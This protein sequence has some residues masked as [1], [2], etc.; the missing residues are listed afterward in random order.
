M[1]RKKKATINLAELRKTGVMLFDVDGTILG[2]KDENFANQE[3]IRTTFNKSLEN[4]RLGIISGNSSD[5]QTGRIAEPLKSEG[6][7]VANLFLYV[8]GGATRVS[9]NSRGD[10]TKENLADTISNDDIAKVQSIISRLLKDNLGLDKY[11]VEGWKAWLKQQTQEGADFEGVKFVPGF[12]VDSFE[13]SV[14]TPQELIDAKADAGKSDPVEITNP[15]IE[16]RDGVQLSIKL[17]PRETKIARKNVDRRRMLQLLGALDL[18]RQ[19]RLGEEIAANSDLRVNTDVIVD[20][21]VNYFADKGYKPGEVTQEVFNR[22]FGT[23]PIVNL[24][25][26]GSRFSGFL[27]KGMAFA[28]IDRNNVMNALDGAYTTPGVSPL[29][30]IGEKILGLIV[31]DELLTGFDESKLYFTVSDQNLQRIE[32]DVIINRDM[33]DE[34]KVQR[35][36]GRSLDELYLG[37][38]G[39]VRTR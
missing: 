23:R 8:N 28:G 18:D 4:F 22:N 6:S 24:A 1:T 12:G 10:A 32:S 17:L 30:F 15:Y 19:Q 31:K 33:L 29:V 36:F 34:A 27:H 21:L 11:E 16:N 7:D 5:E 9:Y 20:F 37:Y 25:G 35:Y 38:V 14:V 26:F 2:K 13:A 39:A 3:G